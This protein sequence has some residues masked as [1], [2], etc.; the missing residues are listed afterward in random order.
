[1]NWSATQSQP[2][3]VQPCLFYDFSADEKLIVD[4]L[5]AEGETPIDLIC[6]KTALPMNKV[7]PTLLNLEFA[8]IVKG[9]PG[10]VFKVI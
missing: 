3:A 4:L 1:M 10:K 9:L 8:G 5:R 6:I 2:D 7:S